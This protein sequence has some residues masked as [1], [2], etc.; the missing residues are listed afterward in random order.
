MFEYTVNTQA[1]IR[2]CYLFYISLNMIFQTFFRHVKLIYLFFTLM[3]T[4]VRVFNFF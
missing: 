4:I 2:G 1:S 3:L